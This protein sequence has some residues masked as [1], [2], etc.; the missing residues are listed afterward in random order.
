MSQGGYEHAIAEVKM[1]VIEGP[2]RA[3]GT[4]EQGRT[5]VQSSECFKYKGIGGGGG[6]NVT[7]QR[8]VKGV[9]DHGVGKDGSIGVVSSGVEVVLPRESISRPHASTR[10]D[11][12]DK[13]KVLKKERPASL[14]SR[15]FARVLEIGQILVISEDRDRVRS[16]L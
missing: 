12:P 3:G 6:F 16:P 8:E 13:I 10:G 14:S 5:L 15:E 2:V 7:G 1:S 4:S 11:S 9:D